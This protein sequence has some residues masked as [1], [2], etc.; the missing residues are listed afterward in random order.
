MMK[1]DYGLYPVISEEFCGK[2]SMVDVLK[3][4]IEGGAKIVQLRQKEVS[5]IELYK[6][7]LI[8]RQITAKKKVKLIIND[9][10]DIALAVKADGVH[11]GQEDLPCSAARKI[12]PHF[13]IG[14]STHN[15]FEIKA[16]ERDKATY[17]NIGPIF[18]T[19]TKKLK[20]KPLGLDYLQDAIML[21][22]VPFTVMGGINRNNI[23]KVLECGAKNIAMVTAITQAPNIVN[24][25]REFV[26]IIQNFKKR[27]KF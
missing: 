25:T 13:I 18:A 9:H 7:A 5:K 26:E 22:R 4:I 19:N 20:I 24:A 6:L 11:L 8:Y 3:D 15:F 21:T 16:A 2:R 23:D 1:F 10:I 27:N 12:A 14:V 17:I